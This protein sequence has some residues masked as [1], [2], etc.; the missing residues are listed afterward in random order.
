[1]ILGY[2]R[3]SDAPYDHQE[4][5]NLSRGA[6]KLPKDLP[7]TTKGCQKTTGGCHKVPRGAVKLERLS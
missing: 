3:L 7:K 4:C 5:Q 1:M 6:V 2:V